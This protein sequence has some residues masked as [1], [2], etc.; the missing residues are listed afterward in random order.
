MAHT[1]RGGLYK[2]P[3][4]GHLEVCAI[5]CETTVLLSL[6]LCLRNRAVSFTHPN[7]FIHGAGTICHHIGDSF[8]SGKHRNMQD[9]MQHVPPRRNTDTKHQQPVRSFGFPSL[10]CRPGQARRPAPAAVVELLPPRSHR[11]DL[12][13]PM[14]TG[15]PKAPASEL[16]HIHQRRGSAAFGDHRPFAIGLEVI[17]VDASS[18]VL[19]KI[20]KPKPGIA[21][22][23]SVPP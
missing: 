6:I 2:F 4:K 8:H 18:G 12:R 5:Y 14:D 7:H 11:Y 9:P 23:R 22:I 19:T 3:C 1:P 10:T 15:P 17:T 20:A 21:T 13:S 16:G